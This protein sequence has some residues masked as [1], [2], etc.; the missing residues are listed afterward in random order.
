MAATN[1]SI[2]LGVEGK[3]EIKRAFDEVGKAGQDAFRGVA[4][5]MD[6]AGAAA[7]RQ[8][9]RLQR[10]AEAAKQ[11][12]AADQAQKSFNQV[13]GVSDRRPKSARESAAVFEETA[14]AA[15]D[16]AARTAALRA[17][18]DPLGA[19]QTRLNAEIAE[20]NSLFKAGAITAQEQAAA[21]GLAQARFDA[22]A[23]A[24]G[25]VGA[26]GKLSSGQLVNLS[27]QLN[28]VVVS[29]AGG[30]R[31]L[32]VLMQQGSQ[33]AQIFGPGAG[34]TGV[35]KGVWQ[36]LTSLVTPTTAVVGGV[37]GIVGGGRLR[38]YSLYRVAEGA[39]SGAR[40]HGTR[41]GRHG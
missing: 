33:I 6:A 24:L 15:E 28:D 32:M 7:D 5:S 37:L 36:G 2:R 34:V 14:R 27:Y 3:A 29:L 11:A 30:Q 4:T 31:P 20:A 1:V 40:R 21:H 22:T 10:L 17:Q 13:L 35:L 25:A 12:A 41:G 39:R 8:T 16:L 38:L 23:K 26:S 9:Q 18:I 19:A